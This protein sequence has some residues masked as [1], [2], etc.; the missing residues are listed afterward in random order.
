MNQ[1]AAIKEDE[2]LDVSAQ[3]IETTEEAAEAQRT[4]KANHRR[5]PMPPNC[6]LFNGKEE[7]VP[8]LLHEDAIAW[9]LKNLRRGVRL[10]NGQEVELPKSVPMQ[11][12]PATFIAL[13]G[14]VR[15]L[16]EDEVNALLERV[17]RKIAEHWQ[18]DHHI[19]SLA[20]TGIFDGKLP[21]IQLYVRNFA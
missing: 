7:G 20:G 8:V 6:R 5:N 21:H 11:V 15:T 4:F 13:Q 1:A 2:E 17:E 9:F 16:L 10:P 18:N 19:E 14:I 3:D 12:P